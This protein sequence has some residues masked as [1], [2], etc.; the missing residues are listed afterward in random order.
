MI[1]KSAKVRLCF[2]LLTI[3]EETTQTTVKPAI[4]LVRMIAKVRTKTVVLYEI[5]FD[6]TKEAKSFYNSCLKTF[7]L[8]KK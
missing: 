1:S 5:R 3:K 7:E 2:E 8:D 4:N 6:E